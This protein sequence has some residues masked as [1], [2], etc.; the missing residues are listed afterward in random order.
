MAR[1]STKVKNKKP[2]P[3][4][5]K[6]PQKKQGGKQEEKS[7]DKE[8]GLYCLSCKKM[9]LSKDLKSVS[10]GSGVS[11]HYHKKCINKRQWLLLGGALLLFVICAVLMITLG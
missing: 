11:K 1:N 9:I 6:V 2:N 3:N 10:G 7:N 8:S 5:P 4:P